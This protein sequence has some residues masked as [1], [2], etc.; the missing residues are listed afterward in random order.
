MMDQ[1]EKLAKAGDAE[2]QNTLTHY[3]TNS[4]G[5]EVNLE[6]AIE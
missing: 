1:I 5:V 4:I 6:K 3:Y 2:A